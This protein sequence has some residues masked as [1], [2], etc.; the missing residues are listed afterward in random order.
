MTLIRYQGKLL[1]RNGKL[2]RSLNC[3]CDNLCT[4][5]VHF[6]GQIIAPGDVV[7]NPD[8]IIP[9]LPLPA[10]EIVDADGRTAHLAFFGLWVEFEVFYYYVIYTTCEPGGDTSG[11]SEEW[12]N[13]EDLFN[14]TMP[15]EDNYS[16]STI[17][18]N[19]SG[20]CDPLDISAGMSYFDDVG[21]SQRVIHNYYGVDC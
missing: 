16:I 20:S 21:G 8:S 10:S 18:G 17:G 15:P 14:A 13:Y 3:C 19:P 4:R 11:F 9:L 1:R 12:R 6:Y 7:L 2:A 5:A